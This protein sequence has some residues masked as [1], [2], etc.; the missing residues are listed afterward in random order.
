MKFLHQFQ[1]KT[2][3]QAT[4]WV[5]TAALILSVV[6][7]GGVTFGAPPAKVTICHATSSNVNPYNVQQP[8][9]TAD[10][11]GHDG[12]EGPI[13]FDGI[14]EDWGDIIPPF[15]Y[16]G[17]SYPGKNWT[18]EGQAIY[19]LECNIPNNDPTYTIAGFKYNDLNGNGAWDEG[20]GETGI[21]GWTIYLD[22][23]ENG[24]LDDGEPNMTTV[25]DGSYAF[26]GLVN[27]PYVVREE[28]A[29]GWDQTEPG[30]GFI[31]VEID[32]DNSYANN[33]GNHEIV[34]DPDVVTIIGKLEL[35]SHKE[36]MKIDR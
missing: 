13:W 5:S 6:V 31:N 27:G 25:G 36:F 35:V 1:S 20:E 11:G 2:L 18:E 22:L 4:A 33:F 8:N 23:N 32:D 10:V 16:D 17:G 14:Q 30:T 9:A 34:P 28:S 12:H 24:S 7:P 19:N 3:R 29:A 15:D 21:P 26:D